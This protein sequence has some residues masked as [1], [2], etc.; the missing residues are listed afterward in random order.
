MSDEKKEEKKAFTVLVDSGLRMKVRAIALSQGMTMRVAVERL[1][2]LFVEA[3][4]IENLERIYRESQ[5]E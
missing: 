4:G 5:N 3:D 1:F 2:Q